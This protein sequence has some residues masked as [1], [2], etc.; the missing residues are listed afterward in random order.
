[1]TRSITADLID[2]V[3]RP[4]LPALADRAEHEG[5]AI[6]LEVV[7]EHG[8]PERPWYEREGQP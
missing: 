4:Q 8:Y 1:M 5:M 2:R 3:R 6:F 7:A